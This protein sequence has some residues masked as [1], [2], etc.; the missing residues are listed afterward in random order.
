MTTPSLAPSLFMILVRMLPLAL[1]LLILAPL[2]A[3][4]F[5][6]KDGDRVVFLGDALIEGE[7]YHA[8]IETMLTARFAD[9]AIAFRNLGWS[10]D[11]PAGDSRFGLS[12]LQAG[13]EPADEG[14]KQ[15]VQQLEEAKPTVAFIGYGMASTF[16]GEAGLAAFRADYTRILATLERVSPG[17]RCVLLSP[18]RH[19]NLGTP[20]PDPASHNSA[21]AAYARAI[22]ELAAARSARFVTLQDVPA[23]PGAPVTS[24]GIHPT[25]AGYRAIAETLETALFGLPAPAAAVPAWRTSP[26][27]EALR[28]AIV[29]KNEWFFHRSRPANMAYIFGFRKKEQGRN[30][31]E[32]LQFD[33]LVAA[34]EGR[35]A[36]LRSLQPAGAAAAPLRIGNLAAPFT[37]QP[38]PE[39]QV[40]DGLEVTLWAKNP[41][42]RKP[43][44]IAFDARGR[45]WVASSELY[46][47]IEPG[48]AATDRIVILED[49]TG[50]GRADKAT[51]FADGLL[52][53][54]GLA[55]GDNGVYVAQCTKLLHFRDTDGD[56]KADVRRTVLS[57]FGT[58]DTHHNLHTLRW[59]PG[60]HLYMNQSVYT[61]TNIE[62]PHGVVRLKA[63]GIFRFDPR[64]QRLEV[65]YRGW[66]NAWGHAFD[67]FGQ[68]FVT[69]GAGNRG[70]SWA[71]PGATYQTLAPTRR[72]L[73]SVS[74]GNYP[75]FCG[76]E[77]VRSAHFPADWQGDL[78][79]CDFRAHRV[80][81]FRLSDQNSGYVTQELPDILRT[82]T[83]SFRPID[84]RLGP[85]GALYVADWSNP[86]IQHG[87]VDF[88]DP[89]RDKVHGRIWRI[90]ARGRDPL[91]RRDLTKLGPA[92]LLDLLSGPNAYEQEQARRLLLERGADAVRPHLTAWSNQPTT[93][94]EQV[95]T[96]WLHQAFNLPPPDL[97]GAA[98]PRVRATA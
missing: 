56:G 79:T 6:L 14:W 69:D 53:P 54:T 23:P 89:R 31:T 58:E 22:A 2:R 76:L 25:A 91:P 94:A 40:A 86:I 30:A 57:G 10:A 13:R 33:A 87:E 21:L 32:V 77:F 83:D 20:W 41:L 28:A 75:K 45:L 12:L 18:L 81:R 70:V 19:E 11:T 68:S 85:D 95:Q 90:A 97:L 29:R 71:V 38:L 73:Q 93:E 82:T 55:V 78:V 47:Q 5:E 44:Q 59:G 3:A 74:P 65:L 37:P 63:G 49:T 43:V 8:W 4:A 48:Q 17:V 88:R 64:D 46:P 1:F 67:A 35:I 39:F 52:I 51:V 27:A 50:A 84:A 42:L 15:L 66:G 96:L 36:R 16:A 62:T 9:R 24:N 98:D 7:Q 34:E 26:H 60:G 80:V 61:R 92:A 72:E